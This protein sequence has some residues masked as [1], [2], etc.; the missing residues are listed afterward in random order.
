MPLSRRTFAELTR[1]TEFWARLEERAVSHR[2]ARTVVPCCAA[3]E[4]ITL[5]TE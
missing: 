4:A 1:N 2:L 5:L 3:D